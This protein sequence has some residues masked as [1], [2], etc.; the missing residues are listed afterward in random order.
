[1]DNSNALDLAAKK[2]QLLALLLDEDEEGDAQPQLVRRTDHVNPPLSFAQQRLWFLDQLEPGGTSYNLPAAFR[3]KGPLQVEA[4]QRSLDEIVRRHESLRTTFRVV[5][6]QPVQAISPPGPMPLPLLDLSGLPSEEQEAELKRLSREDAQRS[7]DLENGPLLRVSLVGLNQAEHALLL[8]IHHVIAD[9]W[10]YGVLVDELRTLYSAFAAG[11]PSP[12]PELPVQYADY[13]IWQREWLSGERLQTQLDYWKEQLRGAPPLLELPTDHPRPP[14]KS[15]NGAAQS[16]VLPSTF[17]QKLESLGKSEGATLFMA[18]LAGFQALLYRY[19]GQTDVVVGSPIANRTRTEVESLIGFFVNTLALRTNLAGNPTFKGLLAQVRETALAAYAHQ[20]LPFEKLVEEVHPERNLSYNPIFQ[21]MFVLQNAPPPREDASGLDLSEIAVDSGQAAFDLTFAL[22]GSEEGL[23]VAA[24][25]NTDLFD[26][27]TITRMLAHYRILLEGAVANPNG[28]IAYLP[29]L[30]QEEARTLLVDWNDTAKDYPADRCIHQLFEE[31]AE[32]APDRIALVMGRETVSYG[33]LNRRANRLAHYLR[34]LGVGPDVMVGICLE[35]SIDMIVALL[36]VLK[37]GGAYVP[38]DPSYPQERLA[39]MLK[40]SEARVLL[41]QGSV[42]SALPAH[43]AHTVLLDAER[44]DIDRESSENP[45][46]RVTPDDL[47]YMIYTSGSTGWPKGVMVAHRGLCNI[48]T[49]KIRTYGI[50]PDSCV[51]QFVAF[52]FDVSAAEIFIAL[53]SGAR[54]C[55]GT[56]DDL[57]P[58]QPLARL[59]DEQ[60]VTVIIIPPSVLAALPDN[61]DLP[62]IRSIVVGGELCPAELV[63][64]WAADHR[65]FNTYGPTEATICNTIIECAPGG[66]RPSIGWTVANTRIY[67]LDPYGQ[68]VPVGIAGEM[69]IGGVGVARGYHRQPGLTAERFVP[70]PFGGEPGARL[71]R[72]GDLARYLSDG[73]IDFVGRKDGQVKIRGFRVEIGEI[74]DVLS[75]HPLIDTCVVAAVGG[76]QGG[77]QLAAYFVPERGEKLQAADL[78]FYLQ[79]TLPD[80]M[81]PHYFVQLEALPLSP[82]GKVDRQALPAPDHVQTGAEEAFE[83]PQGEIEVTLAAIWAEMLHLDPARVGRHSDFFE[84]GGHSLLIT[85]VVTRVRIAFDIELPLRSLFEAHTLAGM[86]RLVEVAGRS[87][88]TGGGPTG[89][90]IDWQAE[91]VLPDDI[92]PDLVPPADWANP[93]ALFITGAS[94]FLGAFVL[95]ELLDQ[96]RA[97]LLCLVRAPD[98]ATGLTRIKQNL[99]TYDLW[100]DEDTHRIVPLVGDLSEPRFGLSGPDY[101]RLAQVDAIYHNGGLVNFIHPYTMLKAANVGGTEH[102]LRLASDVRRK[103][104]HFVSTL[105]VFL[106][107]HK[108]DADLV[109]DGDIP[110]DIEHIDDG[111]SQ[112]KWVAEQLVMQARA[113]GLP[114]SIY[115]PARISGHSLTGLTNT[116]D[117]MSRFIKGCIQLGSAPA[118]D[119][120]VDLAPVD[121]VSKSIVYLSRQPDMLGH[122]FHIMNTERM[123]WH[124]FVDGI[125]TQGYPLQTIP[126]DAW[127]S[128]LLQIVAGQ[129]ENAL[130]P[131]IPLFYEDDET[132]TK[133]KMPRFDCSFTLDRLAQGGIYCPPADER[134]LQTYFNYMVRTGFL[135][136]AR[137]EES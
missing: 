86:A 43:G 129:G 81:V 111:Y 5:D 132:P 41:T 80:Y 121:F 53:L 114:A 31:Q 70:D 90:A 136:E 92:R 4:L 8:T 1:M 116:A 97:D 128:T 99:A 103:A 131:F 113:L 2:R 76:P 13:A 65:F 59:I 87:G 56:R 51:L 88:G 52:S 3:L 7:F 60:G 57:I 117:Y 58:G 28:R 36:G 82:N 134:L 119:V 44:G 73:S 135:P 72:T 91:A 127:R 55:L 26:D 23:E 89:H 122:D 68:P 21:V 110:L 64:R 27:A 125:R 29:M 98:A 101:A 37:A 17:V 108:T 35:R 20:D 106:P 96:T 123:E 104:V 62:G 9:G 102:V 118:W 34:K 14:V 85:Q 42:A 137:R 11:R 69:Y 115:R 54:L 50:V 40:D 67:L 45:P 63:D 84:M 79:A 100:R 15:N 105:S 83:P 120:L 38:L 22:A 25:Y 19:T 93:S 30:T 33:E 78:R 12:L 95:R 109:R 133:R 112:S 48:I 74:E 66:R 71:Y 24:Q 47:A 46:N 107:K 124:E 32:R 18:L 61:A 94:G 39:Y 126:H 10:S 6:G 49:E 75:R 16:I 130:E 77:K